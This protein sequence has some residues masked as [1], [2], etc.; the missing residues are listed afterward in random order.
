MCSSEP[1]LCLSS[2]IDAKCFACSDETLGDTARKSPFKGAFAQQS[3]TAAL[4]ENTDTSFSIT[5]V[6][7][8]ALSWYVSSVSNVAAFKSV[9][10]H[11]VLERFQC[12][13]SWWIASSV[14]NSIFSI[15]LGNASD[16]YGVLYNV[17]YA[18]HLSVTVRRRLKNHSVQLLNCL[19]SEKKHSTFNSSIGWDDGRAWW[20]QRSVV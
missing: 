18:S 14:R 2:Q 1:K 15:L 11:Y 17:N 8:C 6:W 12:N 13:L 16:R 4:F 20:G 7:Y 10:F 19:L 5:R 9:V 3:V